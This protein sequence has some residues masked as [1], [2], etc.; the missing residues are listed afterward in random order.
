V[1]L[2]ATTL[3]Q[4]LFH[5]EQAWSVSLLRQMG[6]EVALEKAP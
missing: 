4:P 3:F 2:S 6:Y 1:V 5:F